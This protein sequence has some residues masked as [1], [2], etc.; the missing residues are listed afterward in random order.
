[1]KHD[2]L[3]ILL[4]LSAVACAA[5]EPHAPPTGLGRHQGA[6]LS[7]AP[8]DLWAAAKATLADWSDVEV[9]EAS[10][11]L[12]ASFAGGSVTVR[13]DAK[14]RAETQSILRVAA[15][16]AGQPAPEVADRVQMEI[17]QSVR[18]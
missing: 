12:S 9:D 18:R 14:N 2:L 8:A 5:P 3:S 1:M 17:Q 13:V 15:E 16:S 10:R 6:V 7:V 11:T 4:A